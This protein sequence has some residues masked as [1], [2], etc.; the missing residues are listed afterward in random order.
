MI[1]KILSTMR[2]VPF[3]DRLTRNASAPSHTSLL[4]AGLRRE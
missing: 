2:P 3:T 4:C 1:R